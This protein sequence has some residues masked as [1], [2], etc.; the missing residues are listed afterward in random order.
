MW[1][2]IVG[3]PLPFVTFLIF[4]L[5]SFLCARV[6]A[7]DDQNLNYCGISEPV[8]NFQEVLNFDQIISRNSDSVDAHILSDKSPTGAGCRGNLFS[9]HYTCPPTSLEALKRRFGTPSFWG[10]WTPYQTRLFYKQQ[11]PRALQI[12]GALGLS[13]EQRAEIASA[14]RHAL[15][16]YTRERCHLPARIIARLY[17]GIRH[18]YVFGSWNTDGMTWDE[19]KQKYS[20]EA[21]KLG[22]ESDEEILLYVYKRI[23]DR[24]TTTNTIFDDIAYSSSNGTIDHQQLMFLLMKSILENPRIHTMKL[25]SKLNVDYKIFDRNNLKIQVPTFSFRLAGFK[26]MKSIIPKLFSV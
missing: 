18:L 16:I 19:V 10:D 23:V 5:A 25:T 12:D 21:R 24:S 20:Y 13:L 9:D 11:L 6:I 4:A 15:R 22:F 17:D 7:S 14:N 8:D 2:I 26:S 3:A 1:S